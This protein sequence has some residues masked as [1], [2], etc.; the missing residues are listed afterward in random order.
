MLGRA[1]CIGPR[2]GRGPEDQRTIC[3]GKL[4]R[5]L[6]ALESNNI[7]SLCRRKRQRLHYHTPNWPG[8]KQ[9]NEHRPWKLVDTSQ[10]TTPNR[11]KSLRVALAGT[12]SRGA[13]ASEFCPSGSAF[14]CRVTPTVTAG[15][16][17]TEDGSGWKADAAAQRPS[18]E[19][20][21][22]VTVHRP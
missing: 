12:G 21:C 14:L 4:N 6:Q 11:A 17:V 20:E 19:A 10:A 1:D 22:T 2:P 15:R 3:Y 13:R 18:A 5:K 16:G 8:H 7:L 9:G